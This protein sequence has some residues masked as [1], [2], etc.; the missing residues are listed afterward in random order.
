MRG[1]FVAGCLVGGGGCKVSD[2]E[3]VS[4]D[5][6]RMDLKGEVMWRRDAC[7]TVDNMVYEMRNAMPGRGIVA[8]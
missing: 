1:G 7:D 8:E 4:I 6:E 3:V 2:D 5:K